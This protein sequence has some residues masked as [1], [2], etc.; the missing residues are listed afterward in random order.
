MLDN[1]NPGRPSRLDG[2][3]QFIDCR[4]FETKRLILDAWLVCHCITLLVWVF[5]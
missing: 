4:L 5:T 2:L 1:G 3:V